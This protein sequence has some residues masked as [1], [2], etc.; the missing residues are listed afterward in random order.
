[1]GGPEETFVIKWLLASALVGMCVRRTVAAISARVPLQLSGAVSELS[2]VMTISPFVALSDNV[3][4]AMLV[5]LARAKGRTNGDR[6]GRASV[7][8]LAGAA[9]LG[10]GV[11][12]NDHGRCGHPCSAQ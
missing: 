8:L 2:S 11:I 10:D 7:A 4:R 9:L 5:S 12:G 3:V 1:V 6:P